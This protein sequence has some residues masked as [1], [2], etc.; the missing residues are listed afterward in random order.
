MSWNNTP[1]RIRG[2]KPFKGLKDLVKHI[3][4]KGYVFFG[5]KAYHP[6][7]MVNWQL[8]FIVDQCRRGALYPAIPNPTHPDHRVSST[9]ATKMT[10]FDGPRTLEAV[11]E[12]VAGKPAVQVYSGDL[13]VACVF[14]NSVVPRTPMP[15]SEAAV[16][17]ARKLLK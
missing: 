8:G 11:L 9:T 7:V 5:H 13:Y 17:E 3:D 1:K 4:Q 14:R 10:I 6:A 12:M 15:I 16:K 2:K